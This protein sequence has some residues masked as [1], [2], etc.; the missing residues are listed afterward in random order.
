[1]RRRPSPRI[2]RRSRLRL[3]LLCRRVTRT[4]VRI[5]RPIDHKRRFRL[6]CVSLLG[7]ALRAGS[8]GA[9][10]RSAPVQIRHPARSRRLAIGR[11]AV[12]RRSLRNRSS[13]H[14]IHRTWR[15][16]S[17]MHHLPHILRRPK[18][19]RRSARQQRRQTAGDPIHPSIHARSSYRAPILARAPPSHCVYSS[20][21]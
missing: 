2:L 14:R 3:R 4:V 18:A 9:H 13:P 19:H 16:R 10:L 15:I 12:P 20:R 8:F 17:Q 5:F 1:M 21:F 7:R 6:P 11:P